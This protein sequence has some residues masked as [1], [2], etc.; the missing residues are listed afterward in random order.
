MLSADFF[1]QNHLFQ[2]IISGISS[3][4]Q[5]VWIMIRPDVLSGLICV[6]TVYKGYQQTTLVCRE[7]KGDSMYMYHY[8]MGLANCIANTS[9]GG[10]LFI[11]PEI[12]VKCIDVRSYIV[13]R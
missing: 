6:Q 12:A 4:C 10:P 5:T 3:G 13:R 1:F 2:K 7:V 9:E 11:C 8:L